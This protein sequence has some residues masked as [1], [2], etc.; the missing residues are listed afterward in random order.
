MSVK[1]VDRSGGFPIPVIFTPN[2]ASSI[3]PYLF[4][5]IPVEN[6][7][8]TSWPFKIPVY[9][10]MMRMAGYIDSRKGWQELKS[11]G[12][13][14]LESGCS[15]IIWPEG[16][17]SRDGRLGRFK[18]GAFM[19]A[20]RTATAVVPVYIKGSGQVLP[21]GKRY[22]RPG[23][24]EVVLLPPIHPSGAGLPRKNGEDADCVSSLKQ[25]V[26]SA[27]TGEMGSC[28]SGAGGDHV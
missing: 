2:H 3:D 25:A 22:I 17:R 1:L 13:R 10:L 14:L 23:E 8:V 28:S 7:F 18:N 11:R 20:C 26:Y 12:S 19:L 4:G 21:P 27:I 15:L 16:H 24:V 9:S 5:L 6:A